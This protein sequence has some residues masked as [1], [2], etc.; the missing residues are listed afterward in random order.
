MAKRRIFTVGFDLPGEEFEYIEFDSDQTLLDADIVLFQ[1]QLQYHFSDEQHGGRRLLTEHRSHSAKRQL[2][3]WRSEISAAV[4]AGKLVI[5]YLTKPIEGYRYTGDTQYSGSGRSRTATK[6]ITSISSYESVPNLTKVTPKSG[7][8]IRLEREGSY[9]GPYWAD[10][11]SYSPYEVEIEGNFNKVLLSSRSGNRTVGAAFHAKGGVLLFLPPL[12]YD[13][14]KFL[15]KGKKADEELY[16]TNEAV[17][18]GKQLVA[19]LVGIAD[20]LK[21]STQST[22]P[23]AWVL[24]SNYRLAVEGELESAISARAAEIADLQAKRTEL[25]TQLMQAGNLRRLLF[26]Q[27][28]QLEEAALEAMELLG[29]DVQ[30]FSDGDSEFDVVFVSPEGSLPWR[31]RGKRYESN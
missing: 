9:L 22:P 29:F 2:D 16:W 28:V 15:R 1:P 10:F 25:E 14:D 11:S 20:T 18:F 26:E 19:A 17:R 3:H 4:N 31:G 8:E 23:P 5:V 27:G 12:R 6:M 13:R 24:D 7:I 30:P 21:Q